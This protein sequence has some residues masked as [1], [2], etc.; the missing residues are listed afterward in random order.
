MSDFFYSRVSSLG[1]SHQRQLEEAKKIISDPRYIFL[2]TASGKNFK[3][4]KIWNTLVGTEQTI[5]LMK[6]FDNL[7]VSSLDRISRVYQ[8]LK[9]AI[10]KLADMQVTL[11][12]LDMPILNQP[13]NGLSQ[14]FITDLVISI[15]GFVSENERRKIRERCE[16][17]RRAYVKA[18]GKFGPTPIERPAQW[19]AVMA[20]VNAGEITK[21][22]AMRSMGLRKS[23]FYRL[24][25]Q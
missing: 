16:A 18:G 25:K 14:R 12:V 8:D 21:V 15:M 9:C 19:D 24:L 6:P 7:Y 23:T 17:G 2:E 1:Q 22:E 3:D 11:H 13:I 10:Q 4:R 5:G 20:R